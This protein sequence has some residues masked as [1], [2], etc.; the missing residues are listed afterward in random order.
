MLKE[1][2]SEHLYTHH[3][4]STISILLYFLYIYPSLYC[5]FYFLD[6]FK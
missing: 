4:D 1:F 5:P 2:N 3:L 6:E